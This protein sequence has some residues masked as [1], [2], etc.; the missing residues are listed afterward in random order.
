MS[1]HQLTP[2]QTPVLGLGGA[3]YALY[4]ALADAVDDLDDPRLAAALD[5]AHGVVAHAADRVL[6]AVVAATHTAVARLHTHPTAWLDEVAAR[7]RIARDV[8]RRMAAW[9]DDGAA[10][11]ALAVQ[12]VV[13]LVAAHAASCVP[14]ATA[15]GR[16]RSR[17]V[18]DMATVDGWLAQ[19]MAPGPPSVKDL[20]TY[21]HLRAWRRVVSVVWPADQGVLL[22]E[23]TMRVARAAWEFSPVVTL[24]HLAVVSGR[25]MAERRGASVRDVVTWAAIPD[26]QA[27]E[28]MVAIL[29][30]VQYLK[31]RQ[32]LVAQGSS[33]PRN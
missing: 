16:A 20:P 30:E 23:E 24:L 21:A 7:L 2:V 19:L 17:L 28:T 6:Q 14:A 29:R 15:E 11:R 10:W 5:A 8:F 3:L 27:V 12:A 26:G 25:P 32:Q 13:E 31:G 18:T 22:G 9:G 1:P 33:S 4:A